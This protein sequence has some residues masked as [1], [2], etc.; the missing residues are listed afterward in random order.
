MLKLFRKWLMQKHEMQQNLKHESRLKK[1]ML[2]SVALNLNVYVHKEKKMGLS[3]GQ[4]SM[5]P[6]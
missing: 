3:H 5:P 6:Q 4:V 1:F 2:K